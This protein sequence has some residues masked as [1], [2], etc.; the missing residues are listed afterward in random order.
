MIALELAKKGAQVKTWEKIDTSLHVEEH[1]LK[2]FQVVAIDNSPGQIS[3]GQQKAKQLGLEVMIFSSFE[4][5]P[6]QRNFF[7]SKD[8][9]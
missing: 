3:A 6:I 2:V 5:F 1:V 4:I 8:S 7:V 9:G